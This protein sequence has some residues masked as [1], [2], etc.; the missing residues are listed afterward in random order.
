MRTSQSATDGAAVFFVLK[1]ATKFHDLQLDQSSSAWVHAGHSY[2]TA[3]DTL[4]KGKDEYQSQFADGPTLV[5]LGFAFELI[6]KS[7]FLHNSLEKI[8][9][10]NVAQRTHDLTKLWGECRTINSGD[11]ETWVAKYRKVTTLYYEGLE[12]Q[13]DIDT[14]FLGDLN[15]LN[16]WTNTPYRAR[17]PRISIGQ[18]ATINVKFLLFIGNSMV[19]KLYNA[20]NEA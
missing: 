1:A 18:E 19:S 4:C 20:I 10:S 8:P 5:L 9:V 15:R 11:I 7:D 3:V 14:D 16:D 12:V 17:Y 13:S 2:L 6:F